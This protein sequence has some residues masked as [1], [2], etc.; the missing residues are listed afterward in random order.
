M[1]SEYLSLCNTTLLLKSWNAGTMI[2]FHLAMVLIFFGKK[3]AFVLLLFNISYLNIA[4]IIWS[5]YCKIVHHV[6]K[7]CFSHCCCSCKKRDIGWQ[8]TFFN[9][10]DLCCDSYELG[11]YFA[12]DQFTLPKLCTGN[13]QIMQN[14][15]YSI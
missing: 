2:L 6:G 10:T 1:E 7:N 5:K 13:Y 9:E 8:Y 14:F 3:H 4:L 12:P 15:V 11:K